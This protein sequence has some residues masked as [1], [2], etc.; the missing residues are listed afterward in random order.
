LIL[1]PLPFREGA[2]GRG[3]LKSPHPNPPLEGEGTNF[4]GFILLTD[5]HW[6]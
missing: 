5:Q 3:E 2:R 1:F 6:A 4:I